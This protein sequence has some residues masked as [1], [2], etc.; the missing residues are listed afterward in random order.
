MD[1]VARSGQSVTFAWR[2][3]RPRDLAHFNI[4]RTDLT[5]EEAECA[6]Q[7]IA[8][9]VSNI[10]TDTL[11]TTGHTY[12]YT[13]QVVDTSFNV[14]EP[15]DPI[16]LT[17][18]VTTALTT[19]RVRVPAETPPDE[20]VYI[21]GDNPD[22][23]GAPWD[24]AY[25]SMTNMGDGIW[26]W[27]VELLDGQVLQYKY[28]RGSWDR[29]EQ[30]GTISGM[31]NRRVQ[32][33]RLEDGTALVDNTSTEWES[34]APDE[35]LAV[36]T[37]RDPLVMSTIPAADSAGAVET[38]QATFAIGVLADDPNAVIV[39]TDEAGETVPGSVTGD[40]PETYTWTPDAPLEPGA[41]TATV[42]NVEA[43]IAMQKPYVWSFVV[44]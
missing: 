23:F 24:P 42:F 17:A 13:V 26:E 9:A 12:R 40:S 28:A 20:L 7:F 39:V 33:T 4:C 32:I 29:V 6:V 35:T 21:A 44:E 10:F 30:W 41:Y 19:F 1:E 5:A 15:S 31:A 16:E 27:Q 8:P 43:T 14:S 38:V 22:V 18:E 3:S 11:V 25:L 37:W 2:F 34:D 36:Q